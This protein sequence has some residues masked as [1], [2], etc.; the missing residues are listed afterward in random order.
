MLDV[1]DRD[2]LGRLNSA[3]KYPETPTYHFMD[4]KSGLLQEDQYIDFGGQRVQVTEK[5]DGT[6]GRIIFLPASSG[7]D[8]VIGS[9]EDLLSCSE[10]HMINPTL[11]IVDVLK[12]LADEIHNV[13]MD[14]RFEMSAVRVYFFEVYGG[15]VGQNAKQYTTDR[16]LFGARLFDVIEFSPELFAET[17]SYE[18]ESIAGWRDRGGQPFLGHDD[19]LHV[20]QETN[21]H[22]VPVL[23]AGF[24]GKLLPCTFSGAQLVLDTWLPRGSE[25]LLDMKAPGRP[26]GVVLKSHDRKITAKM[27]F[28]DYESTIRRN[29]ATIAK[30]NRQREK[31]AVVE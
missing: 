19:F 13:H 15:N 16:S 20:S 17:M 2:F 30:I 9:R 22:R 6:N 10:D 27:R 28:V 3:T 14:L 7:Q 25:A 29:T 31:D 18:R 5:I 1:R 11:G 24:D 26:E 12:P 8:W 21:M 23:D 4:K